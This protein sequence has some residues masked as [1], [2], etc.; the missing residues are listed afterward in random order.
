MPRFIPSEI[1]EYAVQH[2]TPLPELLEELTRVTHERLES[3]QMLTGPLEGMLLQF[4]VWALGARRVLEIG[5][6]SGFSVGSSR[7]DLQACK[8]EYSIVSP[9]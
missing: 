1:E 6:F 5:T 3:P 8:L 7:V 4:L 2:T 9:K